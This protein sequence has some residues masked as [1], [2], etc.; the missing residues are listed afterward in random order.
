MSPPSYSDILTA[1]GRVLSELGPGRVGLDRLTVLEAIE[2]LRG[3]GA[4]IVGGEI[5]RISYD[6]AET[7]GE[8]W[9]CE[10]AVGEPEEQFCRRSLLLAEE[11]VREY[12]D[13]GDGSIL[14]VLSTTAP[15]SARAA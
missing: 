8:T 1:R 14:Y 9:R 15:R 3:T 13:P 2:S 12:P 6:R 10:P 11:L 7:T 4:A 5:V